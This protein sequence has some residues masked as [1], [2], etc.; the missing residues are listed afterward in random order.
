MP[1][2][3]TTT[4]RATADK[5]HSRMRATKAISHLSPNQIL[6]PVSGQVHAHDAP[7]SAPAISYERE[8]VSMQRKCATVRSLAGVIYSPGTNATAAEFLTALER[9]PVK[10]RECVFR[11][12]PGESRNRSSASKT[13]SRKFTSPQ[14]AAPTP[15][16]SPEIQPSPPS[17]NSSR[18]CSSS[19][20][21]L[22]LGLPALSDSGTYSTSESSISSPS[23]LSPD[24]FRGF[25]EQQNT[26]DLG[27]NVGLPYDEHLGSPLPSPCGHT[28]FTGTSPLFP[29]ETESQV[30]SVKRNTPDGVDVFAALIRSAEAAGPLPYNSASFLMPPLALNYLEAPDSPTAHAPSLDT[31]LHLFFTR[32]LAQVPLIHA[33]TWTMA[34]TPPVLARVF[35]ACGALFVKTPA[36][37][38]FVFETLG[39][40]TAEIRDE[41][42][43]ANEASSSISGADAHQM[44]LILALVLLQTIGLFQRE[45][46]GPAPENIQ[47]HHAMLV[48]M[49][50]QTGLIAHVGSWKA[51]DWS[52]PM[53]LEVAWKEWVRFATIKRA[54]LLAYFHDCCHCMYSAAPPAFSPAELDVQLPCD[55]ALWRARSAAEW[56]AAAH[57]P[58]PYGVGS[59][60]IYGVRMQRVLAAL[61]TPSPNRDSAPASASAATDIILPP[62]ALLLLIHTILRNIAVAQRAP[63]PGGDYARQLA[64]PLA[65]E[66]RGRCPHAST[67][68]AVR[69]QLAAVLLARAG[70]AVGES[71]SGPALWGPTSTWDNT[72]L[73]ALQLVHEGGSTTGAASEPLE[74]MAVD[75]G[76]L[77]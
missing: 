6:W 34:D 36:A 29:D 61:A 66:P 54:L 58:S 62:F 18:T 9:N 56:S 42:A 53:L 57:T 15:P 38:A 59:A 69:V 20:S 55:D 44:H 39:S 63:P 41:F 60:R 2:S 25:D 14:P 21:S 10:G 45:R 3:A 35:H 70:L 75:E 48:M 37:A 22:S 12:D 40:V 52:D 17:D 65:H 8:T 74:R 11:N 68:A 33:P 28:L 76:E 7:D 19:P 27:F 30:S 32:F 49:I 50:R 16:L 43:M 51:P 73:G 31:Y 23:S 24:D 13:R 47:Q 26:F 77:L 1:V 5:P 67:G 71:G 46:G 72:K 64:A 4:A